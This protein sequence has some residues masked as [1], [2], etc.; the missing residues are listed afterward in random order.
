METTPPQP[1]PSSGEGIF[2]IDPGGD[3]S[4]TLSEG[5]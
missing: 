5:G 2:P 3:K 4:S 1:L